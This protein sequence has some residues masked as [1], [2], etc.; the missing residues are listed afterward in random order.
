MSKE[1]RKVG[2]FA[3]QKALDSLRRGVDD[4]D[5][6]VRS[7]ETTTAAEGWAD[8]LGIPRHRAFGANLPTDEVISSSVF[9]GYNFG[10]NDWMNF[11][12]HIPHDYVKGSK[13]YIHVHWLAD[14]TNVNTVKWEFKYV[15]A[16]GHGQSAFPLTSPTT[17]TVE[18]K[19]A[20]QHYHMIAEISDSI[21]S[22]ELEP[23][24][25]VLVRVTRIVNGATDNTDNIY[26][27]MSDLHYRSNATPTPN[28]APDFYKYY[29]S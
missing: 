22:A 27:I 11:Q 23:D 17:V 20:G 1:R 18:Q 29:S 9:T 6:S 4:L 3:T 26:L 12:Y 5:R 16:K 19:P 8:I 14:G 10:L 15:I 7:L 28:R 2:D 13:F 21:S 24:A 25:I